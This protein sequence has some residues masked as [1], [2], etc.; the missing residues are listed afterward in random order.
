M[1]GPNRTYL[2]GDDIGYVNGSGS[3]QLHGTG[4]EDFYEGGWYWNRGPFTDPLNGEPSREDGALG[5]MAVC[6]SAYRLMIAES[7]PFTKSINYG[8]EHGNENTVQAVYS[9]TAFWYQRPRW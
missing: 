2:E 6:D 3:P 1:E 5:C 7:I 8:I 9:S 4:T